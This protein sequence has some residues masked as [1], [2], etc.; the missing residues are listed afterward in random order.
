MFLTPGELPL[1][2]AWAAW[3]AAAEHLV[4][5]AQADLGSATVVEGRGARPDSHLGLGPRSGRDVYREQALF[6]LYVHASPDHPKYPDGS[7]FAG[8]EIPRPTKVI[9]PPSPKS[10]PSL[11]AFLSLCILG[12]RQLLGGWLSLCLRWSSCS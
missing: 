11:I 2:P 6:S 8:R 9:S 12:R 1:E 3:L 7:V 4:P 10:Y 5:V